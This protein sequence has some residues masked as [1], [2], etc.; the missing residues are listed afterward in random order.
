[1]KER[2]ILLEKY[3]SRV[4][5]N[6]KN[7]VT[8]LELGEEPDTITANTRTIPGIVTER[9]CCY[10]GCKGVVVGPMKD[11]VTITHGPIGCAFYSWGTRRNK[12][13][14][15]YEGE[16]NF[17]PYS[18]CTDMRP[19]DIVFGG[20][21]KLEDGIDE[22]MQLFHPKC[23][24]ICST[25]PIGL[26]GDD[27]QAVA[28]RVEKKYGIT[29]IGFSCEGYKGVSQ[30]AGHHIANN[31]LMR[32]VIGVGDKKPKTKY[33]LNILGEYNIGGDGWEQERILKRIGY[34]IVSVFTGDG[35][36]ETMKNSHLADLNLVMCHRSI[37]YVA[38]MM[39]TKYGIDWL[40]VNFIGV[41]ATCKS[42]RMIAQYFDDPE[43]IA[44][45]EE[46]IADELSLISDEI[47]Y[48]KSKL[49]GKTAGIFVG[50]S[51]AHHYQL[52]LRDFGMETIIAG[53][54]FAH[55]DDF[56]GR[57]IISQIKPDADSKNIE[58][59][60]VSPDENLYRERYTAEE[61]E[62]LKAKGIELDTYDG[63]FPDMEKGYVAVDDYN[64]F[65]TDELI[66]SMK[67][68]IFFSG[69][70]DKYSIQK[71]GVVS[72]QMHSYDYSGPYAGFN[73]AVNFGRDITMSIYTN[74]W[75]LTTPPWKVAPL[76]GGKIG[77]EANA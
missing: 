35:S 53:Y 57:D 39:K 54:E 43:L 24:F 45:T 63:M 29:A 56:E 3:S 71:A 17:I 67:P 11:V 22:I 37:N 30:S 14:P 12:A 47:E 33:S 9:G 20:E 44:R 70:K 62:A 61:I 23:I 73:G 15:S 40:K 51:R 28:R 21:K 34:E 46:V 55:R 74:A 1:M 77:G 10:A 6:R 41:G 65:E 32:Q 26:I 13:K 27:V 50:G 5:K 8:Q 49:K 25:C 36:F 19:T 75:A 58:E 38:Q 69:I 2:D 76:L 52:L 42:L 59:I 31:G 64:L 18:F 48:Y 16:Q 72:R 4:F 7:H 66:K 68:D 60:T